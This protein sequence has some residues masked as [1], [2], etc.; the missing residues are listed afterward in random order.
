[1]VSISWAS[2]SQRLLRDD[3]CKAPSD[4]RYLRQELS[5]CVTAKS[6]SSIRSIN[7]TLTFSS[8]IANSGYKQER[9]QKLAT[10]HVLQCFTGGPANSG[11]GLSAVVEKTRKLTPYSDEITPASRWFPGGHLQAQS[12]GPE[13][14]REFYRRSRSL[15]SHGPGRVAQSSFRFHC[16]SCCFEIWKP[17]AI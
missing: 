7:Y 15:C 13:G 8:D 9:F 4:A 3:V 16:R 10:R 14:H 1:M 5:S 11:P 17:V 2:R 6:R 12:L